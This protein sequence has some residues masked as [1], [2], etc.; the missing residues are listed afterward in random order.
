MI[1]RPMVIMTTD[2]AHLTAIITAGMAT[3]IIPASAFMFTTDTAP[4]IAGT[5]VSVAIG[6]P[7]AIAAIATKIGAIIAGK[8]VM[9]GASGATTA[10]NGATTEE[11]IAGTGAMIAAAGPRAKFAYFAAAV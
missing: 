8:G 1:A 2:I 3:I 6:K 10:A 7:A 4:A 9:T 11:M 5:M